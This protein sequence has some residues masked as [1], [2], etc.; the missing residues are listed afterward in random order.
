MSVGH[1]SVCYPDLLSH[2]C[3]SQLCGSIGQLIIFKQNQYKGRDQT[4][5]IQD[6]EDSALVKWVVIVPGK[7]EIIV[8]CIKCSIWVAVLKLD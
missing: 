1:R 8:A 7:I 4:K 5:S 2:R 6:Q 3:S